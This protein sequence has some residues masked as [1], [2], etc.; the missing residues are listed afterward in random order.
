MRPGR[1]KTAMLP[2][3]GGPTCSTHLFDRAD[4]G[5]PWVFCGRQRGES[6]TL[7]SRGTIG[8]MQDPARSDISFVSLDEFSVGDRDHA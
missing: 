7:V 3:F 8:W 2:S 4:R 5:L 1:G 6:A